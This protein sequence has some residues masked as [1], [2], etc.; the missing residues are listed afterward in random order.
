MTTYS[1]GFAHT[2]L[3][4]GI[5]YNQIIN[6][7]NVNFGACASIN[8]CRGDTLLYF[9]DPQQFQMP[10]N[11]TVDFTIIC[12]DDSID[13][14]TWDYQVFEDNLYLV[15][16]DCNP[17]TPDVLKYVFPYVYEESSCGCNFVDDFLGPIF[18]QYRIIP[19]F[20]S[21][22]QEEVPMTLGLLQYIPPDPTAFFTVEDSVCAPATI[23]LANNSTFGCANSLDP[24]YNPNG[25]PYSLIQP[26][27]YYN[28]GNCE[29]SIYTPTQSQYQN[30]SY[31]LISTTYNEAGIYCNNPNVIG[32]S[33]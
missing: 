11:A 18:D 19:I 26:S 17:N 29:N 7:S 27:F 13:V 4:Y 28:F 33:S 3:S 20:N 10:L 9:I 15:D 6:T 5:L 2:T 25:Q 21:Y 31:S 16:A 1:G 32:T 14:V 8:L 22:C 12:S 23:T 24:S 30:S